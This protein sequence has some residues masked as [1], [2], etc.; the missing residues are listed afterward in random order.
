M[1]LRHTYVTSVLLQQDG[2]VG[3]ERKNL[4]KTTCRVN[5]FCVRKTFSLLKSVRQ[6]D[7][8]TKGLEGAGVAGGRAREFG[9]N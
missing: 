3:L 6:R 9:I 5:N 2:L 8:S 1:L 4:M 7:K